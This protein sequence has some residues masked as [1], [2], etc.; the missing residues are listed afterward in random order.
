MF[1]GS[2]A[3]CAGL[4]SRAADEIVRFLVE[5]TC[6]GCSRIPFENEVVDITIG[7]KFSEGQVICSSAFGTM[8]LVDDAGPSFWKQRL[9]HVALKHIEFPIASEALEVDHHASSGYPHPSLSIL[10]LISHIVAS[11]RLRALGKV[12]VKSITRQIVGGLVVVGGER[13]EVEG[14]DVVLPLVL[15]ATIKL[16]CEATDTV[17]RVNWRR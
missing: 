1:Q 2:V 11:S 17:S 3:A 4:K 10:N 7:G 12:A 13:T 8:L 6:L 15:A 5:T 9:V 16:L 14:F